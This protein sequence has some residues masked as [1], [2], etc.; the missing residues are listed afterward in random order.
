MFDLYIVPI[1]NSGHTAIQSLLRLGKPRNISFYIL[2]LNPTTQYTHVQHY[3][4]YW[5]IYIYRC[6]DEREEKD[7]ACRQEN[8][9]SCWQKIESTNDEMLA[10]EVFLGYIYA[11]RDQI[12]SESI[13]IHTKQIKVVKRKSISTHLCSLCFCQS[14]PS[15][16]NPLLSSILYYLLFCHTFIISFPC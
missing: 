2:K 14:S 1:N 8:G 9:W 5:Y 6:G 4:V 3:Y 12:R 16:P 7:G 11:W 10:S 13:Y 15:H